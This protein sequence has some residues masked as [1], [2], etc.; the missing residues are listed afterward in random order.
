MRQKR[1]PIDIPTGGTGR[2]AATITLTNST[3][4][5]D[6]E[7]G[8]LVGVLTHT[9]SDPPSTF[10]VNDSRFSINGDQ[11]LRS[12]IGTLTPGTNN[13]ITIRAIDSR[14]RTVTKDFV[15]VVEIEDVVPPPEEPIPDP[16]PED[17]DPP[18]PPPPDEPPPPTPDPPPTED[19]EPP[20]TTPPGTF[21]RTSMAALQALFPIPTLPSWPVV[22]LERT[23][24]NLWKVSA[25]AVGTILVDTTYSTISAA[26]SA[27]QAVTPTMVRVMTAGNYTEGVSNSRATG[28]LVGLTDGNGEPT[29]TLMP[30]EGSTVL[31][32]SN[33][34]QDAEIYIK[35]FKIGPA[36]SEIAAVA[37]TQRGDA[38]FRFDNMGTVHL[39]NVWV[40]HM[41]GNGLESAITNEWNSRKWGRVN[42]W[43]CNIWNNGNINTEHQI[44]GHSATWGIFYSWIHD[45]ASGGHLVKV[46]CDRLIMLF[47]TLAHTTGLR[48]GSASDVSAPINLTRCCDYFL[49]YNA[50][51]SNMDNGGSVVS[52]IGRTNFQ[53]GASLKTPPIHENGRDK[54]VNARDLSWVGLGKGGKNRNARVTSHTQGGNTLIDRIHPEGE[55]G[56]DVTLSTSTSYTIRLFTRDTGQTTGGYIEEFTKT[57]VSV[58]TSKATFSGITTTHPVVVEHCALKVASAAWDTPLLSS[59]YYNPADPDY[60][61]VQICTSGS[62]TELDLTKQD[63]FNFQYLDTNF[64][65]IDSSLT[66]NVIDHEEKHQHLSWGH[67]TVAFEIPLSPINKPQ[68]ATAAWPNGASYGSWASPLEGVPSP[69]RGRNPS[70]FTDQTS[71][72]TVAYS[73]WPWLTCVADT[74]AFFADNDNGTK[75]VGHG[76]STSLKWLPDTR[77]LIAGVL[78]KI[79]TANPSI[80]RYQSRLSGAHSQGATA[81]TVTTPTG[82]VIGKLCMIL[83]PQLLGSPG[84]HVGTITDVTGSVVTIDTALP[85]A[86]VDQAPVIFATKAGTRP[87]TWQKVDTLAPWE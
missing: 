75:Y 31:T 20:P 66:H 52:I 81:L 10:T 77:E 17:P 13:T 49:D 74:H 18:P 83:L 33:A 1:R 26:H 39:I 64:F 14:G 72:G 6:I 16:P 30:S 35:N 63:K 5:S 22:D 12:A 9:R 47:N 56:I 58:S 43:A 60:W 46:D 86:A 24:T 70:G 34:N 57:P 37:S 32:V 7:A 23:N 73:V 71:P 65:F 53:G 8:S 4:E 2:K 42:L 38:G 29:I 45:S 61:W 84:M 36:D 51:W 82:A 48:I 15:I 59:E 62:K 54:T 3:V 11:L 25:S 19:P 79:T 87:S 69:W 40:R 80:D 55:N 76:R 28:C 78:T 85:R 67:N 21:E 50:V 68:G 44:Y 41:K 27:C